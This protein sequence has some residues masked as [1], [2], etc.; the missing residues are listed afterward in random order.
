M[1]SEPSQ[2]TN[3]LFDAWPPEADPGD[4]DDVDGLP[5]VACFSS[6]LRGC[7]W[8]TGTAGG[9]AAVAAVAASAAR[10]F[11]SGDSFVP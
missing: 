5:F 3:V 11:E 10:F 8:T 2:S 6:D 9:G 1:R 7:S 4:V